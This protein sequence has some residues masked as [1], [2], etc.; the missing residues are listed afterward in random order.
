MNPYLA[1]KPVP[2]AEETS[3]LLADSLCERAQLYLLHRDFLQAE[4]LFDAARKIDAT[5]PQLFYSQ[6]LSLFEYGSSE[7]S[8]SALI[9][10]S[11]CFKVALKLKT[12]FFEASL[13]LS[14]TLYELGEQTGEYHYF[15]SAKDRIETLGKIL[16][17][18][19]TS[20]QKCDFFWQKALILYVIAKRTQ[21]TLDF[22][23]ATQAFEQALECK[24]PM[25]FEFWISYGICYQEFANKL[26]D[27]NSIF[28]AIHCFKSALA[29][30]H[31]DF[32]A[33]VHLA[34]AFLKL[35]ELLEDEDY[36][37]QASEAL[38]IA[39]Q[40]NPG[41]FEIWFLWAE[42]LS[43]AGRKNKD[44]KRLK[45][46]LEK[47]FKAA[48]LA[49]QNHYCLTCLF[50]E[51]LS[52]LG[53]LTERLDLI[54]DAQTKL[55]QIEKENPDLEALFLAQYTC[56]IA[57]GRYF[58][59]VDYFYQAIE[60]LQ[61]GLSLDRTLHYNWYLM[62]N[63]Y[64]EISYLDEDLAHHEKAVKFLEKAVE[65][66]NK[67]AYLFD[68]AQAL[69][70]LGEFSDNKTLIQEAL[71]QYEKAFSLLKNPLYTHVNELFKYAKTLLLI[72]S[73]YEEE[74]F[75]IRA[76][77]TFSH[78][79]LMDPDYPTIHYHLALTRSQ[80][81]DLTGELEHFYKAIQ[82]FRQASTREEDNEELLLDWACCLMNLAEHGGHNS[83]EMDL[84]MKEAEVKLTQ[85]IKLGNMQGYY[86]YACWHA[87][88]GDEPMAYFFLEK[89]EKFHALPSS[90]ELLNDD[91]LDNIQDRK[92]LE[93]I[94][95]RVQSQEHLQEEK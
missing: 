13:A 68:Y 59:D 69:A 25:P 76:I 85:A 31:Q 28:K 43:K 42:A 6:G 60:K 87:L 90:E 52:L 12:D 62:G 30:A 55:E 47:C 57:L 51:T 26:D 78:V 4:E 50:A 38:N 73:F 93:Q 3:R 71:E 41:S 56:Y 1:E 34:K 46:S 75:Y 40:I 10:A 67:G 63:T 95:R 37:K 79:Q 44:T 49:P 82:H 35:Y 16:D 21:E 22:S 83:D 77:E 11:R 15:L 72:G 54:Y 23:Q 86:L 18:A 94:A 58:Q 91:W 80:L 7:K 32:T 9:Q 45:E 61:E 29:L 17:P 24:N 39:S 14:S 89:A 70:R 2:L 92:P 88:K 48:S 20:D 64:L 53:C 27:G 19:L 5:N 84:L 74:F 65:L 36:F 66:K 33:W 81:A 8:K